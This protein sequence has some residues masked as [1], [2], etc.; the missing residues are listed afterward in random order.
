MS[1]QELSVAFSSTH[2]SRPGVKTTE[3]QGKLAVQIVLTI[4]MILQAFGIDVQL[5]EQTALVII[6]GLEALYGVGR[7]F[8]KSSAVK[9]AGTG[10]SSDSANPPAR[11]GTHTGD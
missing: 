3:F 11:S 2:A 9:S 4:V 8:V 7:S 5:D 1:M 6:A 10:G